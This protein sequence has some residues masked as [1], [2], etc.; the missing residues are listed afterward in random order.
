MNDKRP[1]GP[2]RD[3]RDDRLRAALRANLA[4][5]KAQA[6]ARAA[7]GGESDDTDA[8]PTDQTKKD[9]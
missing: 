1:N 2:T 7:Q 8:D 5:R 4:R 9:E 6:R 3:S